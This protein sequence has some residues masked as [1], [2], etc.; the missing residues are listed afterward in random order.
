MFFDRPD[1]ADAAGSQALSSLIQ[2]VRQT[3][4]ASLRI[5]RQS[6]ALHARLAAEATGYDPRLSPREAQVLH[7]L[8][9]GLST[10]MIAARLGISTNTAK[11]HLANAYRKLG[12]HSRVHAAT[13]FHRMREAGAGLAP[14]SRP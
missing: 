9:S 13:A 3:Q 6:Q 14:L 8:S 11:Y 1:V 12:T 2:R 4:E 5:R 7:L 10:K